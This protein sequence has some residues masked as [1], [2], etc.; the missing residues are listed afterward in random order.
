MKI[1][2]KKINTKEIIR[3]ISTLKANTVDVYAADHVPKILSPTPIAIVTNLDTSNK[4]GSHWIAIYI[5]RNG[6]GIYFDSY[7]LAPM[8]THH[9]DRLIRN[10]VRFNGIRKNYKVS[11]R[12][13]AEN[14]VLCFCIICVTVVLYARF[15]TSF[16]VTRKSTT[17]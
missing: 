15:V 5:D 11:I 14:I 12:K 16:Q 4:P 1:Y 3:P 9:L 6:Y 13:C 17:K 7:G 8:L 10:C 2:L